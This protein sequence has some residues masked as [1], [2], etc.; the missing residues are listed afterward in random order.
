MDNHI[1][2]EPDI[3]LPPEFFTLRLKY[4]V[5]YYNNTRKMSYI[6]QQSSETEVDRARHGRAAGR[7]GEDFA[8]DGCLIGRTL[9]AACISASP[10]SFASV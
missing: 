6:I 7:V 1:D 9:H 10:P 5:V 3:M 2:N 4:I 8:S